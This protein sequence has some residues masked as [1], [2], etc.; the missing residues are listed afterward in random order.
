MKSK[1]SVSE[2]CSDLIEKYRSGNGKSTIV[3]GQTFIAKEAVFYINSVAEI[4]KIIRKNNLKPEEGIIKC[5]A[6]TE[7]LHKLDSLSRDTGMKF[8]IVDIPK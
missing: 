4:K 5:S 6:K 1:K 3:N 2:L 7:N 8:N